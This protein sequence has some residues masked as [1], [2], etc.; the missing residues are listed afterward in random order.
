[1]RDPLPRKVLARTYLG[2]LPVLLSVLLL[3]GCETE[4]Y[5]EELAYPA[6]NDPLAVGR[7]DRDAVDFD[8]PGEFPAV[9]FPQLPVEERDKLLVDPDRMKSDQRAQLNQTLGNLFGT[10]AHP[11]VKGQGAAE[12]VFQTLRDTLRLDEATLAHGSQLYRLHCLHCHGLSGDG[13][14]PTSPWVNPHPRDYRQGVFKFTSS[15]QDEGQRRPRKDDLVRTIHEGIEGSSM[16]SFRLLP[17]DDIDALASYVIHLSIRGEIE[18]HLIRATVREELEANA[19]NPIQQGVEDY[20]TLVGGYWQAAQSS[21][22]QPDTFPTN[23]SD[24]E[25]QASAQRGWKLFAQ[26]GAAGCI[27]CHMDYGRQSALKYDYWGTVVR[28]ADVTTG[29]YRGGRRPIDLFWRVHSGINGTGM[30]AFGATLSARDIWDIVHFLQVLPYA[31]MRQ[32]YGIDLE[33]RP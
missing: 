29:I 28:P 18:Y 12:P 8:R 11:T 22:I 23:P 31:Q 6:R 33:H 13:R 5:P 1:V 3:S 9:L 25:L 30:T 17:D 19:P 4:G 16:P 21:L 20:L 7:A 27:S 10:P 24:A 15:R 26:Q 14:G 2:A 32:K